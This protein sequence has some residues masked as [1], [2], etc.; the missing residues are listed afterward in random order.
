MTKCLHNFPD[1]SLEESCRLFEWSYNNIYVQW[2]RLR[3][4]AEYRIAW[5]SNN[6]SVTKRTTLKTFYLIEEVQQGQRYDIT[7]TVL[8][9]R[10]SVIDSF[11]C[12]GETGD[13]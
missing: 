11:T 9:G 6:T 8:T 5:Y 12:S 13:G 3:G 2:T 4:A 1:P 10:N 7:V